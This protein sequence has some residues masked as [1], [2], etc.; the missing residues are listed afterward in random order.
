MPLVEK[1]EKSAEPSPSLDRC[2]AA[3]SPTAYPRAA[4]D[5]HASA[6]L[7]LLAFRATGAPPCRPTFAP[8]WSHRRL[9]TGNPR[10]TPIALLCSVT[11]AIVPRPHTCA[12]TLA[13]PRHTWSRAKPAC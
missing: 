2:S 9:A 13:S 12:H 6:S 11:A 5:P 1:K 7:P 10:R 3:A 8:T 4:V